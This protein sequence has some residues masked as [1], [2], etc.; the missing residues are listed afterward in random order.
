[1]KLRRHQRHQALAKQKRGDKS[2][3]EFIAEYEAVMTVRRKEIFL[4]AIAARSHLQIPSGE[5]DD[6]VERCRDIEAKRIEGQPEGGGDR[7]NDSQRPAQRERQRQRDRERG[8]ETLADDD[9][10]DSGQVETA[11]GDVA[12]T[13]AVAY[14]GD[15]DQHGENVT[16]DVLADLLSGNS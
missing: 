10:V 16:Q 12:D 1:M 8:V 2:L 6:F 11:N 3:E 9:G 15:E 13:N 5:F 4:S 14:A 7:D